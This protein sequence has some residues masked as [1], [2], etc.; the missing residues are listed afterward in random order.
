LIFEAH[1]YGYQF[2]LQADDMLNPW[3]GGCGSMLYCIYYWGKG[4]H[5]A[6][7][8]NHNPSYD[9]E[10]D[11]DKFFG[12]TLKT[13]FVDKGVPVILGEYGAWKRGTLAA[14]A[15]RA[16]HNKS[17]EY[18]YYYMVKTALK[19]GAIPFVWD[20]GSLFDRGTGTVQDWGII[21]AMNKGVKEVNPTWI[22]LPA[23][24]EA[25]N[26]DFKSGMQA[27]ATGDVGGGQNLGYIGDGNWAEYAIENTTTNTA[28]QI[29]FRLA[30]P[31][32]GGLINF[33]LDD[34]N[35]GSV[36]AP[37]TGNW[38]VY[39]SVLSNIAISPG[40]HYLKVVATKS[41]FNFNYMDIQAKTLGVNDVTKEGVYIYPNPVSNELIINSADFQYD[42]IEVF[43]TLGKLVMSKTTDGEPVLR[44]PVHLSNGMYFVKISNATQYQIKKIVVVNK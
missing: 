5:S 25:E 11:I 22:G 4:N 26:F 33:Y 12:T 3:C 40:K 6:T 20:T 2:A 44:L 32:A 14:G 43:D 38:Q 41:G 10:A 16:L 7:D 30:A 34:V 28:Y 18:Y 24:I 35:V 31:N 15:D 36:A 42:K 19:N 23:K 37:N 17:I 27:E 8:L 21:N 13:R 29:S 1:S 39:Q 9:E